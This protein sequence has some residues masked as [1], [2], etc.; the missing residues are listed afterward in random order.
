MLGEKY[1]QEEAV[2]RISSTEQRGSRQCSGD[3]P[4][5]TEKPSKATCT[6]LVRYLID[7]KIDCIPSLSSCSKLGMFFVIIRCFLFCPEAE[8]DWGRRG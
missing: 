4:W 1:T 7:V 2:F 3:S 8:T 6:C 5:V